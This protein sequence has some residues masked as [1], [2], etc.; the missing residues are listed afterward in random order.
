MGY[1]LKM[2]G[3][4]KAEIKKRVDEALELVDLAGFAD[5]FVDQ[6]SGDNSNELP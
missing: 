4:P 2:L 1:G 5:R 3:L 6:I